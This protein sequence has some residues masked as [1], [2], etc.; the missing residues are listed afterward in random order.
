MKSQR[1]REIVIKS[2][3]QIA[4]RIGPVQP[5]PSPFLGIT[6]LQYE[7]EVEFCLAGN[8]EVHLV[9]FHLPMNETYSRYLIPMY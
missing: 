3:K 2:L 6:G 1:K 7:S 4:H 8:H 5:I 9:Y